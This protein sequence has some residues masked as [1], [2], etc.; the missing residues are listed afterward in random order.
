M[1]WPA[2]DSLPGIFAYYLNLLFFIGVSVYAWEAP[3]AAIIIIAILALLTLLY[4]DICWLK[5]CHLAPQDRALIER[6]TGMLEDGPTRELLMEY[7]FERYSVNERNLK[8][9]EEIRD[10]WSGV[11]FEFRDPSYQACWLE[12]R[13][14][15]AGLLEILHTHGKY[16]NA[17]NFSLSGSGQGEAANRARDEVYRLYQRFRHIYIRKMPYL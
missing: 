16:F 4:Q 15:I 3:G 13:N 5:E 8:N 14:R 2:R 7:D 1:H 17:H 11:D 12:M 6:L 9:L 10:E